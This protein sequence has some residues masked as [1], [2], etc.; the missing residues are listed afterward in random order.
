VNFPIELLEFIS[1]ILIFP[2]IINL[3]YPLVCLIQFGDVNYLLKNCSNSM[4]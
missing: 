1:Q 3:V 2:I 4:L